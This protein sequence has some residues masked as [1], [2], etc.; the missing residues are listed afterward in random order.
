[1]NLQIYLANKP[2]FYKKIDYERFPKAF[3][4][5]KEQLS[6]KNV[7]QVVGTNGKGSTGRFLAQILETTGAKVGH[8]T[9]PHIFKFNERFYL[10]GRDA[11]DSELQNAHEVLQE[12]LSDEFK[13]SL[14]YFEYA[15]LIAGILFKECDYCIL[16]A[17]MGAEFDAT[18]QYEKALSLFT[19]IGTDHIP[20]LG[21]NLEEISHT[22]LIN[23]AKNSILNDEMDEVSVKIAKEI[24]S[25]NGV[26]LKF[27]TEF[28]N[29]F[30][31]KEIQKYIKKYGYAE[32]QASNLA[33]SFAGA[34]FFDKDIN[35]AN[36]EKLKMHGRLEK[37]MANL[38]IDVGHNE[39]AA[40][41]IAKEF[42]GQKIVLIYNAFADKDIRA[43]F[44][45]LKPIIKRVEIFDY[46][47][48]DR[49]LGGE[50]ITQILDEFGI[51][52]TKF[53]DLQKDENYLVFGSFYLVEN[54]LNK[55]KA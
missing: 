36:L 19:P 30:D 31:K 6:L 21:A 28:L 34:K 16:E 45:I 48:E 24:A 33:L 54:F 40:K 15:T 4:S 1:M 49:E 25:K 11:T 13:A 35:L 42:K 38:T 52:H 3:K 27:A 53:A 18:S 26:N 22:K 44:K 51:S 39:L 20:M 14:S 50:T 8:Y 9:S 10:N 29:E 2:I 43:I 47:S 17:G 37:I 12:I 23:M 5:I 41:Q 7:V 55:F 32:F 46:E